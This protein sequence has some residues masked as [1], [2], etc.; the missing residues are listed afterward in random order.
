MIYSIILRK[1]PNYEVRSPLITEVI[2]FQ[3]I[4]KNKKIA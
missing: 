1:T 4:V 3:K 2:K